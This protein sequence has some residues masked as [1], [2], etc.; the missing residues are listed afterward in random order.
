MDKQSKTENRD[1]IIGR[2]AV[3]EALRSGSEID[4]LYVTEGEQGSI[5]K[6]KSLAKEAGIVIKSVSRQKLD[7][8][9]GSKNHQGVLAVAACAAYATLEELFEEA[10]RKQKP[11]FFIIADEIED[12]HNLGA[13]LRTAEACGADGVILPK[14]RSA[15][16]NATVYKTSSGAASVIKVARVPNLVACMKELKKK[17]LFIYGADMQGEIWAKTDL[18][19]PLALVVGS[20]GN[21]LSRLVKEECD[22]LLSLPMYGQINSLNAS[23]AAGVLMYEVVRQRSFK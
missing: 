21:G 6:I 14:R 12:P 23:V 20:E 11:P 5:F 4:T 18:T 3:F 1:I 15:S 9:A 2:N 16:L 7:Q 19:G 10:K 17:N 8:M 22:L 13:I